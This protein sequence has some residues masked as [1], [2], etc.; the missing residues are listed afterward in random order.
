MHLSLS[1]SLLCRHSHHLLP[2]VC[3]AGINAAYDV[4]WPFDTRG[5]LSTYQTPFWTPQRVEH[6][7]LSLSIYCILRILYNICS[8]YYSNRFMVSVNLE[9]LK[10]ICFFMKI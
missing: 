5:C 8:F 9:C 6:V 2:L 1:L 3:P 7:T 10:I 4:H